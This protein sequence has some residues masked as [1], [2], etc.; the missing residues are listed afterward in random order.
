MK[1]KD[2]ERLT[3]RQTEILKRERDRQREKESL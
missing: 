3:E 2:K 1:D